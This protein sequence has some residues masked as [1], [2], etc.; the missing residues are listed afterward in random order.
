MSYAKLADVAGTAMNAVSID[1]N[2]AIIRKLS[3][4]AFAE[5][6]NAVQLAAARVASRSERIES[7]IDIATN[8]SANV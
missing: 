1:A 3:E 6:T 4:H 2:D 8:Q 7:R 5:A